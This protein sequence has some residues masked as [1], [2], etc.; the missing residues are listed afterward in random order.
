MYRVDTIEVGIGRDCH[1]Q[2]E[3]ILMQKTGPFFSHDNMKS[4]SLQLDYNFAR[5]CEVGQVH[6]VWTEK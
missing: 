2:Q 4:F 3:I 6:Y 1:H 5:E